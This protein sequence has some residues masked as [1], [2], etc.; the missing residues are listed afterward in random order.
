MFTLSNKQYDFA[1]KVIQIWFPAFCTFYL[2]I[3]QLW[4]LPSP[5]KVV[6]TLAAFAT[7]SGVVLG[8]SSKNYN[9]SD[10][11]P[12]VEDNL[13]DPNSSSYDTDLFDIYNKTIKDNNSDF[14]P[15][16]PPF[17]GG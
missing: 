8:I 2:T 15:K 16:Q 14:W 17:T 10:P 1:K 7:F 5:E 13:V 11:E 6:G 12:N 4:G 3:G 9:S